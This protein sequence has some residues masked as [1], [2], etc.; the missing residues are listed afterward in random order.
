MRPGALR[1][2]FGQERFF[3]L[4]QRLLALVA[5]ILLPWLALALY[6]QADERR[7]AIADVHRDE[8]RL[9]AIATSNQAAEIEA[10]RQLLGAMA[11]MPQLRS[12]DCGAFLAEMRATAPMFLNFGVVEPDGEISCSGVPLQFRVNVADRMYIRRAIATRQFAVGEYQI[13]R[14]TFVP[15]INYA[16]PILDAQGQV[17]AVLYAA[18]SLNW[19]TVALTKVEFPAGAVLTVTDRHNTVLARL[20]DPGDVVGNVLPD[21][22]VLTK[23]AAQKDTGVF[24]ANDAGG[25]RRLWAHARLTAGHD[26][27]TLIGVSKAIAF[28]EVDR[29]L[30]RN[31]TALA[32]VTLA[33]LAAAWFGGGFMLRQV[34]ALVTATR[35]LERGELGAQA[36]VV[37]DRS[38]LGLLARAFNRMSATLEVRDRELRAAEEKTRAAEI[39]LAVAR[40]HMDIAKQIQRSLLP[41]APVTLAGM[42]IAGRCIPANAVGGDYFGYFPHGRDGVDSFIG[43][44]SGHGVGAALLMAE[45]RVTFLAERMVEPG[46]AKILGRL[47]GLLHDDLDRA[48]HFISACCATFDAASRELKYANAGHPPA[49]LLRAKEPGCTRLQADGVLL[50]IRPQVHFAETRIGMDTGDIVVLYTD[51]VTE[52]QNAEGEL[53]GTD[54]LGDCVTAH[55]AEDPEAMVGQVI[56]ALDRFA[57]AVPRDD[58]LTI[59]V[60]KLVA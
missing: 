9:L 60:M 40:A 3:S 6:T 13:G 41:D 28:A 17:L 33:A 50:G 10:A 35:R 4:R 5:L 16:Q 26:L 48:S 46:A 31:L 47:N 18:E 1:L 43:D 22:E 23:M 44:V 27:Q 39:D 58:D 45:A 56:A 57:G 25:E 32:L 51:G 52:T 53:F 8:M 49:L 38:D 12:S 36:P 2:N 34:D 42:R 20:P 7:A 15:S 11:R 59:V 54:R 21:V 30:Y 37:G 24:E 14:I 55:R 19:L 29:R